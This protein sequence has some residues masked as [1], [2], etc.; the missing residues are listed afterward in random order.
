[1]WRIA[2]HAFLCVFVLS[3]ERPGES[4]EHARS[5]A[6]RVLRGALTYPGSVALTVGAGVDA[7]EIVLATAA[8]PETVVA[9]YKETLRSNRWVLRSESRERDGVV[10]L[11]AER[12]GRPLWVRLWPGG[13]N[14]TRYA[15]IG[16]EARGDTIR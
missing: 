7:A 16:A 11:Y 3:C 4:D 8:S 2:V 10:T 13:S 6:G 12:E 1:M 14:G 5:V 9:W 15:L